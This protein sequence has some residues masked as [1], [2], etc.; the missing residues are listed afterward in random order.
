M[1][2]KDKNSEENLKAQNINSQELE[3]KIE[4]LALAID[5]VEDEKLLVQEQLKRALADYHNLLANSEKREKLR[6]L[7]M[8]KS[9]FQETLPSLDG[10][11]MAI[12]SSKDIVLDEKGKAWLDGILATVESM[13]KSFASI[14]LKQ[15]IPEKGEMFNNE[16]HEAIAAVEGSNK[17]EIIDVLQ[18]GYFLDDIVIRPA[19]V[20]VSK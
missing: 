17:G 8:K 10:L 14:G 15:Y 2:K 7:Q 20:V 16:K 4:E 19:R 18:P 5:K 3:Q 9:L 11:M 6:I 13:Y 1:M 12:L